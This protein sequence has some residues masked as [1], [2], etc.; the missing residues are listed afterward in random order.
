VHPLVS[1]KDWKE[2]TLEPETVADAVVSQVLKGESAQ[3]ILPARFTMIAGLRGW[4][5]WLQQLARGGSAQRLQ[6]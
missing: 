1:R 2:F 6:N 4:P 5:S 3:L